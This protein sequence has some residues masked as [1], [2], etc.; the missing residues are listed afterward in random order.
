[1]EEDAKIKLKPILGEYIVILST[2]L[3][4]LIVGGNGGHFLKR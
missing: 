2:G 3:N 4:W 1:M